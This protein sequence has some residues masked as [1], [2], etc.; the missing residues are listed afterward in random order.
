[1]FPPD[2]TMK[3]GF[4]KEDVYMQA[5]E[6]YPSVVDLIKGKAEENKDKT[7]ILFNNERYSYKETDEISSRIATGLIKMGTKKGDRIGIYALNSPQWLF[8]YLGILKAGGIP[9]TIN[10]GFVKEPLIYNIN[11]PETKFL[12][13]DTR[14]LKNYL[15]IKENLKSVE[16]LILIGEQSNIN[17]GIDNMITL[18]ELLSDRKENIYTELKGHD[19]AAMI[20]TSGTTGRSKVVVESNA[21]FIV[22]ALD[23][24]D[25]GGVSA[26]SVVYIYLPL[27]HIM[28]LDLAAISAIMANATIVLVEK[29]DPLNFWKDI[30]KYGITHFHAVGPIFEMLIKQPESSEEKDHERIIAIAYASKEV[31]EMAEKRFNIY[32]TGGYGSTEAGI[33][34]TSPYS[35]VINKKNKPGSCGMPAP[36]FDVEIQNPNGFPVKPGETGEI[37]IRPRLPYVTFLEYYKMP[38]ATINAFR[39]L[40]FHTGDLGK[41]DSDGNIYFVDRQKDSIRRRGENISSFEIEQILLKMDEIR[42][43][44]A[45]PVKPDHDE[46]VM[47]AIVPK[48]KN[49]NAERIIDFCVENM[50]NFWIP[51]YIRFVE[52]LPR[53]PTG[54]VQKYLLRDQAITDDTFNMKDYIIKKLKEMG[55]R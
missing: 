22:T 29:F 21:Q 4:Y 8:S 9:V 34:V 43:A 36:P 53:T 18:N 38:E 45:Y 30:K 28:A 3:T 39:G 17:V 51:N 23:M 2:P 44:A 7:L 6:L 35:D 49:L 27:F 52:S 41:Y 26:D 46:E 31:W 48:T 10:T 15:E 47:I 16:N 24:I 13:V 11:M 32:I 50:P 54:R 19:P 37:V 14:L 5:L 40:W 20:L 12:F 25:A 55:N 1:M 33:P 42:D